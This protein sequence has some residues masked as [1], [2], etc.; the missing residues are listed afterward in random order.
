MSGRKRA[1]I[2]ISG[3][4]SNMQALI[5]AAR[6]PNF[7]ASIALV[8]SDKP[9][10]AGLR[11]AAEAGIPVR[12][13]PRKDFASREA[14]DAAIEAALHGA[15]IELVCLAGYMRLLTRG[16]VEA[17]EG[18]MLNVHPALL[19]SF[20]GLDTHRRALAAGVRIHGCTVHFVTFDTDAGPIIAQAAVPVLAADTAETLAARVLKAE[21]GIY[22]MALALAASG[23]ARM[24]NGRTVVSGMD[25]TR[26][27]AVLYS[28]PPAPSEN[29]VA[30]FEHLARLT[31]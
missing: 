6:Q 29:P 11:L 30:D 9:A 14:H 1:A 26:G 22:P 20:K 4:G 15:G 27:G 3:R 23:E 13:V 28:P 19:P 7:P 17:W 12:A 8:L 31:P 21:H 18:Q 10:A 25:G 2:L 5:E 24:E 16:F